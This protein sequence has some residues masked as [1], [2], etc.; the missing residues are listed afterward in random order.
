MLQERERAVEAEAASQSKACVTKPRVLA[1]CTQPLDQSPQGHKISLGEARA[2]VGTKVERTESSKVGQKREG[3]RSEVWR[4]GYG[5][6]T[7][8]THA[9]ITWPFQAQFRCFSAAPLGFSQT[10][11]HLGF[12][13]T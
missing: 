7:S 5:V 11:I 3:T 2:S 9:S 13:Q 12:K 8:L 1:V 4:V 6:G 10:D